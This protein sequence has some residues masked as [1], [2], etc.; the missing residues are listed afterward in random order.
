MVS[1]LVAYLFKKFNKDNQIKASTLYNSIDSTLIAE[2]N[3]K[4]INRQDWKKNRVTTR[5]SKK[6]FFDKKTNSWSE[7]NITE[8]ICGSKALCILNK[9]KLIVHAEFLNINTL[10]P[11]F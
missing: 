4:F 5:V 1:P 11:I 10:M 7:V 9:Q 3:S 6:S 2:K 8:R